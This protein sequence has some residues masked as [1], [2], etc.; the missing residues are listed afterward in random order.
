MRKI[1]RVKIGDYVLLSRW[2]TPDFNNPWTIGYIV[3]YGM[4]LGGR[5]YRV[6][7][8]HRVFRYVHKI[9]PEEGK[10]ICDEW[11]G[12]ELMKLPELRTI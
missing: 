1:K 12:L 10:R 2:P 11:P 9:T 6:G 4:D 3:E 7:N 8:V 5:F